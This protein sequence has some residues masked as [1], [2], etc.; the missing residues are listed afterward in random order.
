MILRVRVIAAKL[1]N[2]SSIPENHMVKERTDS[3]KCSSDLHADMLWHMCT[4]T[5]TDTIHDLIQ[6]YTI[7][8]SRKNMCIH[9]SDARFNN[10]IKLELGY[11]SVVEQLLSLCEAWSLLQSNFSKTNRQ[12]KS[13]WPTTK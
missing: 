8:L 3:H 6:I 5:G 12:K 4:H 10:D 9:F 11:S 13:K 1:E 7:R 2:L